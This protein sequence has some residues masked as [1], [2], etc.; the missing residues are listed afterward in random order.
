M[1]CNSSSSGDS[2]VRCLERTE[3]VEVVEVVEE[4]MMKVKAG[5]EEDDNNKDQDY[6]K[7]QHESERQGKKG[8]GLYEDGTVT[9]IIA[10][11]AVVVVQQ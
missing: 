2:E 6:N 7:D 4:R 10:V 8:Y 11:T 3:V 9:E 1:G 5:M